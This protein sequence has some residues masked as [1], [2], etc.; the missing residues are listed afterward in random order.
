MVLQQQPNEPI[1]HSTLVCPSLPSFRLTKTPSTPLFQI[2]NIR[3]CR[4]HGFV[5]SRNVSF[6]EET[7]HHSNQ[8][9]FEF[10]FHPNEMNG[11]KKERIMRH[12]DTER[13]VV[14]LKNTWFDRSVN[15]CKK[16][17]Q[18]ELKKKEVRIKFFPLEFCARVA[19][20]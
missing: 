8:N 1:S 13:A 18:S 15:F 2:T 17:Q 9:E 14:V 20:L 19:C 10:E 5:S 7:K 4:T 6:F 11:K 12:R 3:S 16:T